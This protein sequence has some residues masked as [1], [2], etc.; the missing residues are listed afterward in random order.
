MLD[1][2]LL[3]RNRRIDVH[4]LWGF[5]SERKIRGLSSI[6]GAARKY[7]SGWIRQIILIGWKC[8][9][10]LT[11]KL[12]YVPNKNSSFFLLQYTHNKLAYTSKI[13]QNFWLTLVIFLY[14][15]TKY[16]GVDK[17]QKLLKLLQPLSWSW[18]NLY[19]YPTLIWD[20]REVKYMIVNGSYYLLLILNARPQQK[21]PNFLI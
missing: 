7:G 20:N 5:L 11:V 8:S 21:K 9:A 12:N 6:F 13:L 19:L 3:F 17:H 2:L 10:T 4:S 18:F 1:A 14:I 16:F 15:I